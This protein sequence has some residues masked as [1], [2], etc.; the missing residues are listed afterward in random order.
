MYMARTVSE[1]VP[2]NVVMQ[3]NLNKLAR[4]K[5]DVG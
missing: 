1:I 2:I 4:K 3:T 5:D